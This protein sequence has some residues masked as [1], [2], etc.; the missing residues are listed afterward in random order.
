MKINL[1]PKEVAPVKRSFHIGGVLVVIGCGLLLVSAG[2]FTLRQYFLYEY[3]VADFH[4]IQNRLTEFR[5]VMATEKSY[6]RKKQTLLRLQTELEQINLLYPPWRA[7]LKT[8]AE[9]TPES[10][11]IH[12][13][14]SEIPGTV[15]FKGW[16]RSF[17]TVGDFLQRLRETETLKKFK[18]VKIQR[19]DAQTDGFSFAIMLETG[20]ACVEYAKE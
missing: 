12:G 3:T 9:T 1:L 2:L 15:V 18:D 11:L 8:L 6:L 17:R 7:I 19:I 10:V 4:S 16:T 5:K 13:I 14:E 20:G